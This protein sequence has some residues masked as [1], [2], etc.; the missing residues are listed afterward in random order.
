M[1]QQLQ[2]TKANC[3]ARN[4][5]VG[6]IVGQKTLVFL[7]AYIFGETVGKEDGSTAIVGGAIVLV[8]LAIE[9]AILYG[10]F[11]GSRLIKRFVVWLPF[12]IVGANALT[13][14][15]ALLGDGEGGEV[16]DF[17]VSLPRLAVPFYLLFN[18]D[19]NEYLRVKRDFLKGRIS[20]R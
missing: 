3:R 11:Q 5:L 7:L 6:L 1:T 18:R 20:K 17:F 12:F 8:A 19:I 4:T 10:L 13:M 9:V 2:L 15:L 14:A 16:V